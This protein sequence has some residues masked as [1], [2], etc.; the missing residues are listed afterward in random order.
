MTLRHVVCLTMIAAASLTLDARVAGAQSHPCWA[1]LNACHYDS[2]G[3][4]HWGMAARPRAASLTTEASRSSSGEHNWGCGATDGGTAKGRS[5]G[6]GNRTAAT[7][8]ALS[9]CSRKTTGACHIMS[10]SASVYSQADVP[11]AWFNNR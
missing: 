9:E 3:R 1:R 10:C 7:Y 4:M 2:D 6:Y 8:R 5:W 11:S